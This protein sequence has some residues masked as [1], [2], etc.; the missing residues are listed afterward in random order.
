MNKE[1]LIFKLMEMLLSSSDSK[2]LDADQAFKKGDKILVRANQM[3]VQV[4]TVKSHVVGGKL[5]FEESRKLWRWAAKKGLA[6][7]SLAELGVDKNRTRA[8][9]IKKYISIND[10]DCIGI[11]LISDERYKEIMSMEVAEQS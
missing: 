5:V 7:E 9:A 2:D 6:L 8:T 1:N 3:G 4:G 10:T 11:M